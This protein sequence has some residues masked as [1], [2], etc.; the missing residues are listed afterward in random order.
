MFEVCALGD[1]F[2]LQSSLE[3]EDE[4]EEVRSMISG[5]LVM[6]LLLIVFDWK[7]RVLLK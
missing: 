2:V 4:D 1:M 5:L 6:I 3:E 7:I